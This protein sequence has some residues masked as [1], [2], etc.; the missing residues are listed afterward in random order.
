MNEEIDD[1]RE[2]TLVSLLNLHF[3]TE[4]FGG[5]RISYSCAN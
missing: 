4:F 5:Y 2:V 3:W 1:N